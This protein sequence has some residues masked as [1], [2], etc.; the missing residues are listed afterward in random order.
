MS[1]V[2]PPAP[3]AAR[4]QQAGP[5]QAGSQQ[6]R[7]SR[8]GRGYGAAMLAEAATLW[9]ASYL[10]RQGR[11]SLGF[12]VIKGEHFPGA[13][14]PELVI[15]IVLALGALVVLA[16]PARARRPALIASGFGVFGILVGITI[17]ITGG[18]PNATVDLT[19]HAT[20]LAATLATFVLLL[21]RHPH[22]D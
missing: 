2:Q 8:V 17:V 14:I 3:G 22:P 7:P 5:G 16:A 19:Y 13:S 21:L 15:G 4:A 1:H 20:I 9:V 6:P 11:I 10:H 18:S 12:T